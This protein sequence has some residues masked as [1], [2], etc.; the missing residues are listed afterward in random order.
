MVV[1]TEKRCGFRVE[2]GH[3]KQVSHF[4]HHTYLLF[5]VCFFFSFTVGIYLCLVYLFLKKN[6]HWET[7]VGVQEC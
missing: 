4:I 6:L 2:V 3:N 5:E 7:G 1:T